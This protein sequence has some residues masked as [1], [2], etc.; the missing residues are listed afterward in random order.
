MCTI[1]KDYFTE[2]TTKRVKFQIV[3]CNLRAEILLLTYTPH[4]DQEYSQLF[5]ISIIFLFI[6]LQENTAT[7][8][9]HVEWQYG[10]IDDSIHTR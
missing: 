9:D 5:Q 3:R 2:G 7:V 6:F 10:V 4:S 8:N 1:H